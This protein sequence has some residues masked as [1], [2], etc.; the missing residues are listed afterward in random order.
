MGWDAAAST[1]VAA[2]AA[3]AVGAIGA[4]A[5]A[6]AADAS[7][8]A[9]QL[10]DLSDTPAVLHSL[11]LPQESVVMAHAAALDARSVLQP[12]T[13][14]RHK[15]CDALGTLVGMN[16]SCAGVCVMCVVVLYDM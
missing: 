6:A 2:P 14:P 16:E 7:D 9:Q 8:S 4:E 5:Q 1:T 3:A 12:S 10:L 13:A 11:G 15:V